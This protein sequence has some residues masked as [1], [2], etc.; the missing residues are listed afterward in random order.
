MKR[1][2]FVILILCSVSI[3]LIAE[4]VTLFKWD[5]K[6][7]D[8]ME[9]FINEGWK[10]SYDAPLLNVIPPLDFDPAVAGYESLR[11]IKLSF[12]FQNEKLLAQ[13][14]IYDEAKQKLVFSTI[15]KI[16]CS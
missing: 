6:K 14:L 5:S 15:L 4:N 3:N 12:L 8:L 10:V 2:F 7:N 13:T 11:L 9:M 1:L 16:A